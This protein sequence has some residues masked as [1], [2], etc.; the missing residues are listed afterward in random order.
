MINELDRIL[1]DTPEPVETTGPVLTLDITLYERY[2]EE[3]DLSADERRAFLEALWSII[4]SFVDLGF[5]V[6]P[7]Q[8]A[9]LDPFCGQNGSKAHLDV[10]DSEVVLHSSRSMMIEKEERNGRARRAFGKAG[11]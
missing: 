4:V 5:G 2:L 8:Q 11:Q 9:G 1:D 10:P 7:L 6:H 3:A